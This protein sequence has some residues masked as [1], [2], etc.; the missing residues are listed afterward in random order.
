MITVKITKTDGMIYQSGD[1]NTK[2]EA[3]TWLV[4]LKKQA[5]WD[6]SFIVSTTISDDQAAKD[7]ATANASARATKIAQLQNA[8]TNWATLTAAQKDTILKQVVTY[9]LNTL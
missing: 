7:A 4:D 1:F 5:S 3:D 8:V 9:L 2:E 6:K